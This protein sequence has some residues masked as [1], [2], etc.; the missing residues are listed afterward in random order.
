MDIKS[1]DISISNNN[2]NCNK[3]RTADASSYSVTL[4][5]LGCECRTASTT[6][7]HAL[8]PE[9][10]LHF[11]SSCLPQH[12]RQQMAPRLRLFECDRSP[13]RRHTSP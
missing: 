4:L 7:G 12:K 6:V 10:S 11:W 3:L 8:S 5:H 2:C 1:A 9:R 13:G